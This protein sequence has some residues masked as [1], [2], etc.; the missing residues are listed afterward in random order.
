[1]DQI[2]FGMFLVGAVLSSLLLYGII[3][4][5]VTHALR[6]VQRAPEQPKDGS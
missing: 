4:L 5:A 2:A 1:M 6:S 3:R